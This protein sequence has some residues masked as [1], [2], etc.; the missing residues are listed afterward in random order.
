MAKKK[1]KGFLV[2]A[3]IWLAIIGA[4][5]VAARC[6]ILPYFKTELVDETGSES[7]YKKTSG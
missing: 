6:F 2:A 1:G 7:R 4:L 3:M 5:A